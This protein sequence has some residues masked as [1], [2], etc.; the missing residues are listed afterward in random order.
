MC[1]TMLY[2]Q[3]LRQGPILHR[4]QGYCSIPIS[5]KQNMDPALI[6]S[7]YR[8]MP[9]RWSA[10]PDVQ[11]VSML[12]ESTSD[13]LMSLLREELDIAD[14]VEK[15]SVFENGKKVNFIHDF[16]SNMTGI[17]DVERC[18]MMELDP[19]LVLSPELFVLSIE[20]GA[21]FDVSR[22]R[23]ELRASLPALAPSPAPAGA[24]DPARLLADCVNKPVYRLQR[25]DPPAIRKRSLD[26]PPHDYIQFSGRHVQEIEITNLAQV[27]EEEQQAKNK[28][29]LA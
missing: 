7:N 4:Y 24:P 12:D 29:A 28:S 14:S 21:E 2:R 20:R 23:H 25:D 13:D 18:Y 1:G 15:I 26:A 16:D 8:V 5:A 11:V 22:V 6:E 17:V 19:S 9:L 10:D 3:V 27:L